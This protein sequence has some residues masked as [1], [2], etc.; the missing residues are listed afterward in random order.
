[1]KVQETL[2]LQ[3]RSTMHWKRVQTLGHPVLNP[4]INSDGEVVPVL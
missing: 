1:M 3:A 2:R 4:V